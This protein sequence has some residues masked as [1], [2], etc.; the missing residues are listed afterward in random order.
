MIAE[1]GR[2]RKRGFRFDALSVFL[3][4]EQHGVALEDIDKIDKQE[5][6]PS[7][8]WCAYR[9]YCMYHYHRPRMSYER[10][11]KFINQMPKG[12]WD[13]IVI[14]MASTRGPEGKNDKKKVSDGTKS[15]LPDGEQD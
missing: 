9:S 8:V 15:S 2:W 14:A 7:W 1:V 10:M 6:I 3:L 11:K 12:D 13:K 4:C 5:Y